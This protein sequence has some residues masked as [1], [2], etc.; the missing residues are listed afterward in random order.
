MRSVDKAV[1]LQAAR[2][3]NLWILVRRTNPASLEYIGR[4]GYTPKP[5]DCKAKTADLNVGLCNSAGLVVDP[6]VQPQAFSP[7]KREKALDEWRR[8]SPGM[9]ASGRYTVDKSSP[10]TTGLVMLNGMFLHGDYDLYDIINPEDAH[11]NLAAVETLLGQPHRRGANF[12]RVQSFIN[13][14][15]G[16]PMIQHGGEMQYTDHSD[17]AVDAFGPNGQ[18]VTILNQFSVRGWYR[19]LFQGRR[20]LQI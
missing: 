7:S 20:S 6:T 11:R 3:M 17:Q 10:K 16:A 12:T 13:S 4:V 5:I 8:S 15:I 9:L 18:D 1:F 2:E 19:D 14:R